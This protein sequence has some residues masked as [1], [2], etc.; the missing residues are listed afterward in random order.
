MGNKRVWTGKDSTITAV[1]LDHNKNATALETEI[2]WKNWACSLFSRME[3]RPKA[4]P[5]HV[6]LE[7]STK[8]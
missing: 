1:M 6:K 4:R 5:R 7:D 3:G 8:H 2:P